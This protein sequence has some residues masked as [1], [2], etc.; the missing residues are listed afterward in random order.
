MFNFLFNVFK[1]FFLFYL[2]LDKHSHG[3]HIFCGT[4]RDYNSKANVLLSQRISET[5]AETKKISKMKKDP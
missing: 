1:S 4:Q 2:V 5:K 3:P